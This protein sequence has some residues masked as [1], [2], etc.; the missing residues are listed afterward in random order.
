MNKEFFFRILKL[1]EIDE[2]KMIVCGAQFA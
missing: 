2:F 1:S